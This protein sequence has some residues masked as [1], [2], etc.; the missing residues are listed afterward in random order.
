ME[1]FQVISPAVA[2]SN[3][4]DHYFYL[5][6]PTPIIKEQFNRVI[7]QGVFEFVVN[8]KVNYTES[9]KNGNSVLSPYTLIGPSVKYKDFSVKGEIG[10]FSI[11]FKPYGLYLLTDISSEFLAKNYTPIDLIS[12]ELTALKNMLLDAKNNYQRVQISN[13]YL[14]KLIKKSREKIK[15]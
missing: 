1:G 11:V 12:R 3:I 5:D 9:S 2:L 8:Y 13:D 15:R 7:P 14:I 6:I 10:F 4:V